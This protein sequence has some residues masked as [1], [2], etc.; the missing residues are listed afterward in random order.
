MFLRKNA[1]LI[2]M[3]FSSDMTLSLKLRVSDLG[4]VFDL[5]E[6]M[7]FP[8]MPSYQRLFASLAI[9]LETPLRTE[10]GRCTFPLVD[11]EFTG[12]ADN[13]SLVFLACNE[14]VSVTLNECILLDGQ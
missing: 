3:T 5:H 11:M 9:V 6:T 7:T 8:K 13:A 10:D 1:G 2:L 14:I 4:S 12:S